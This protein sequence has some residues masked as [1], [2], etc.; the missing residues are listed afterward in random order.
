MIEACHHRLRPS[1]VPRQSLSEREAGQ[2][3]VPGAS[4]SPSPMRLKTGPGGEATPLVAVV[5]PTASGKTALAVQLAQRLGGE[6]AGADSRQVY[7]RLNAGT[8]KPTANERVLARHHLIDIIEPDEPFGL[9]QYLDRATE[10]IAAIRA[11]GRRPILA[12]GTGQYVWALLEGW[13]VPRVEPHPHLR[14]ALMARA[15]AEG[16]LALH[17]ELALRDPIAAA[18]IHPHN[19]RRV[20]RALELMEVTGEQPSA[21]RARKQPAV[22]TMILGLTLPRDDLFSRIDRRVEKMFAAGLVEEVE[23]LLACGYS[24]GLP[25]LSG[26]G[27]AQV[28][29]YLHGDLDLAEA[30][31]RTKTAT[32]R[33]ARQQATWFRADDP[34]ITWIDARDLERAVEA[35]ARH[36]YGCARG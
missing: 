27:Y 11:R 35:A 33:L 2:S 31:E 18:A 14:A 32:H 15:K 4:L 26:I 13:Q 25:S 16:V 28:V 29:Q 30:R 7:R 8:A 1:S 21:L 36:L 12:G 22:G 9:A 20:I 17:A 23:M 6:I 5:G 10:A 34:R 3:G 19:V 24:A